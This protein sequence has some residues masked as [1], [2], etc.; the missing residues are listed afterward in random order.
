MQDGRPLDW[1]EQRRIHSDLH[2]QVFDANVQRGL[3]E[4]LQRLKIRPD[5]NLRRRQ[6]RFVL[7]T[8]TL[9]L[10][11]RLEKN[12]SMHERGGRAS[13]RLL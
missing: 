5:L 4:V 8:T 3:R 6:F 10:N 13:A 1:S 9:E 7:T 11:G 12:R 2:D